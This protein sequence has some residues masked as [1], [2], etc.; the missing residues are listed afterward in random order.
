MR[1]VGFR[2]LMLIVDVLPDCSRWATPGLN[3]GI[4][5]GV[6]SLPNGSSALNDKQFV[7]GG[8]VV[9]GHV[10]DTGIVWARASAYVGVEWAFVLIQ[11]TCFLTDLFVVKFEHLL[12]LKAVIF[13][14]DYRRR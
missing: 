6:V 7:D 10:N 1:G 5:D 3:P 8:P 12:L 13:V 14:V 2:D 9:V 11:M 4:V